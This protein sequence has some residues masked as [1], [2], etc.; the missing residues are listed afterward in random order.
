MAA[1]LQLNRSPTI[2]NAG[3]RH[4]AVI[5]SIRCEGHS[6]LN[7]VNRTNFSFVLVVKGDKT[8]R[9]YGVIPPIRSQEIPELNHV[10]QTTLSICLDP[11]QTKII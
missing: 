9:K 3:W 10:N 5:P 4:N 7:S 6:R 2:A 8:K 1:E 11:K